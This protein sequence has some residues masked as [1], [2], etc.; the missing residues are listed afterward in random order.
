M[1]YRVASFVGLRLTSATTDAAE[2]TRTK[3]NPPRI[4]YGFRKMKG[5]LT[6]LQIPKQAVERRPVGVVVFPSAEV[7]DLTIRI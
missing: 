3:K 5:K 2:L 6:R 7:A 4:Q 1:R